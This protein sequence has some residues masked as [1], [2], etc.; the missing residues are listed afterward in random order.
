MPNHSRTWSCISRCWAVATTTGRNSS[1]NCRREAI[2]GAILM[3]SGRVPSTTSTVRGPTPTAVSP[4]RARAIPGSREPAR[5]TLA[6][7]RRGAREQPHPARPH[8]QGGE[9]EP[10]DHD[11]GEAV[12]PAEDQGPG[13]EHARDEVEDRG[14]LALAEP[15]S[16]EAVV[17]V[18]GVGLEDRPPSP[19]PAEDGEGRVGHRHA[20]GRERHEEREGRVALVGPEHRQRPEDVAQE[21]RPRVAEEDPRRVEV[22]GEEPQH[23]S[24]EGGGEDG[25]PH[26]PPLVRRHEQRGAGDAAIPDASPSTPSIRFMTLHRATSHRSVTPAPSGP[27]NTMPPRGLVRTSMPTPKGRRTAAAATW[28][29][30]FARGRIPR[31]SSTTPTSVITVVPSRSPRMGRSMAAT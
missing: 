17:E 20:Q 1:G 18:L 25:G 8:R 6:P 31:M 23:P 2:T 10:E 15:A 19:P 26:V 22:V 12:D 5:R 21:H 3:A 16:Q 13:P 11:Q 30:S 28:P 29:A 14:G 27:T 7:R 4:S 24:H 9:Q